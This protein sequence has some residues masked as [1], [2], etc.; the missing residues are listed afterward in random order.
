MLSGTNFSKTIFTILS[1]KNFKI[2]QLVLIAAFPIPH[3]YHVIDGV[4]EGKIQKSLVQK[5]KSYTSIHFSFFPINP[6][7]VKRGGMV[8]CKRKQLT[9][10]F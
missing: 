3:N 8:I 6:T 4:I 7:K 9:E 5:F 2:G 1:Y 10:I